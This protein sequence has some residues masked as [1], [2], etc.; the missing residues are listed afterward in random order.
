MANRGS[1]CDVQGVDS[2]TRSH[3]RNDATWSN[4][5]EPRPP[6]DPACP[7]PAKAEK[8]GT[9][10]HYRVCEGFRMGHPVAVNLS[11][12]CHLARN[13]VVLGHRKCVEMVSRSEEHT[14]E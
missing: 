3:K 13:D 6:A 9:S 5:R 1:R 7:L 12:K 8:F 14:S 4:G 2:L 10:E 11:S